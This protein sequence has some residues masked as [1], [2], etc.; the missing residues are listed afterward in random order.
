MGSIYRRGKIWW[1]KYYRNGR[2][3]RESSESS[4]E[5]NAKRLLAIREGDI[6]RGVPVGPRQTRI[7]I[8]DLLE[9]VKADYEVNHK[10]TLDDLEAR[11][12]LHLLPFFGRHRASS[13]TTDEIRKYIQKRQ[14]QGAANG[15]I[16]RELTAL[17][18]AYS[19][20]TQAAKLLWKPYV[21]MLAE[22]NVRRGFFELPEFQLILTHLAEHVKPVVRFAFVTG[23]R[24]ISEVLPLQWSQVDFQAETIRLEPGTTKNKQARVFPMTIELRQLLLE[25]WT[26]HRELLDTGVNCP[27]VFPYSGRRFQSFKR[28]WKTACTKAGIS[29]RVAHDFRRTAVRNL[30]RAGI[31]ERVAMEMTGHLT[32]SVFERYNIVSHGDVE[33][34]KSRLDSQMGTI[35]GTD[36][37]GYSN[38]TTS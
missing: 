19:L 27:W 23:W 4:R 30:T 16:N 14:K 3:M 15:T 10:K 9:D 37:K 6:A 33:H 11:C 24:C 20:A 18:R 31:V 35:S 21:P 2:A 25:Q 1:I 34:A 32:R 28:A 7:T 36:P 5:S 26:K 12:R 13:L 29:E 17:K 22:D 38:E 8:A